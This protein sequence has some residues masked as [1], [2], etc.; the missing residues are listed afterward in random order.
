M[1]RVNAPTICSYS[2]PKFRNDKHKYDDYKTS[3]YIET[4]RKLT[5]AET[6]TWVNTF[7]GCSVLWIVEISVSYS[8]VTRCSRL[9]ATPVRY[10]GI[11]RQMTQ[12]S[13]GLCRDLMSRLPFF[14]ALLY[15]Y[16]YIYTLKVCA[17]IGG[18]CFITV[19]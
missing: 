10:K 16:I 2:N 17:G 14:R 18:H 5:G 15:I 8:D 9:Q 4:D 12:G 19:L 11:L 3:L 13:Q 1:R 7:L 6:F